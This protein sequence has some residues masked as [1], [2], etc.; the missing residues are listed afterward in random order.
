MNLLALPFVPV[1]AS[2]SSG[3]LAVVLAAEVL[4]GLC[5]LAGIAGVVWKRYLAV[6]I[7]MRL[8]GAA[9]LLASLIAFSAVDPLKDWIFAIV[10]LVLGGVVLVLARQEPQVPPVPE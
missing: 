10:P 6:R 2:H 8:C 5:A 9:C 7:L 1:L 4:A 3:N